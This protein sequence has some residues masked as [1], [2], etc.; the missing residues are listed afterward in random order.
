MQP[1]PEQ[2]IGCLVKSADVKLQKLCDESQDGHCQNCYCRPMWCI[3]CMG[4]WFACRQDQRRIETWLSSKAH[5]PTC[6]ATFCMLDV[7]S[8]ENL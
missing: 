1:T 3:D 8:I 7:C 5:C 2:C 6:R 4:K